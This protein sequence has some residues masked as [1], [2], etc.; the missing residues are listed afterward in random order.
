MNQSD[1]F[2][3]QRFLDQPFIVTPMFPHSSSHCVHNSPFAGFISSQSVPPLNAPQ[4]S[5]VV[6][7][8][9]LFRLLPIIAK[10]TS[11][12]SSLFLG[13]GIQ[14]DVGTPGD[15]GQPLING[16]VELMGFPKGSKGMQVRWKTQ[17]F[18]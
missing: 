6:I 8:A 12:N 11:V 7:P 3:P 17:L 1:P 4:N 18:S 13:Y 9:S 14:G 5:A 16:V 15:P 10:V 2:C